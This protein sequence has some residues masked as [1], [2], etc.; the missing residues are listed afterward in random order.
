MLSVFQLGRFVSPFKI[1]GTREVGGFR[2]LRRSAKCTP[3]LVN[4]LKESPDPEHMAEAL[5]LILLP[6]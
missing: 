3:R 5:L 2:I 1:V 6:S 4:P